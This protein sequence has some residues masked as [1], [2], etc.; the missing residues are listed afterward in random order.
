MKGP[1]PQAVAAAFKVLRSHPNF[2]RAQVELM[3]GV[4]MVNE[5]TPADKLPRMPSPGR[6]EYAIK[7]LNAQ[8]AAY[9]K[10][11]SDMRFQEAFEVVLLGF[12][13]P[14]AWAARVKEFE[15]LLQRI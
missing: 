3:D 7:I 10:L 13:I 14:Q 15:T 8:A 6:L 12:Y 11:V 4:G 1:N 2:P 5:A 9:L